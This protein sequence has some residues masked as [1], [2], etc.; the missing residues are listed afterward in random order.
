MKQ[1]SGSVVAISISKRKGIPK[2][3]VPD[4]VTRE[5]W[6]IEG[7]IHAGNGHWQ[8]SLFAMESIELAGSFGDTGTDCP[9]VVGMIIA[10]GLDTTSA[11]VM[12]GVMQIL[13]GITYGLPMPVQS[14][15][16]VRGKIQ[17]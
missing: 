15:K 6:G 16:M 12:F 5:E 14:G 11:L 13:T 7:D 17:R 4:V 1:F 2:T 3:N 10:C 9:L 8:I